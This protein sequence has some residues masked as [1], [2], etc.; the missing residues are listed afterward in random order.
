[1]RDIKITTIDGMAANN[2]SFLEIP[3]IVKFDN[4]RKI[5]ILVYG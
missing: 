4:L 3:L 2:K 5:Y 1:M